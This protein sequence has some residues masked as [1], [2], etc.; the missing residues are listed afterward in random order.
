MAE[1][2]VVL[3][4][5]TDI[6]DSSMAEFDGYR[7]HNPEIAAVVDEFCGGA[8]QHE[9]AP[10]LY[11]VFYALRHMADDGSA[12]PSISAQTAEKAKEELR[13]IEGDI[14]GSSGFTEFRIAVCRLA[15][16]LD[17]LVKDPEKNKR[18]KKLFA[19]ILRMI[20]IERTKRAG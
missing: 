18:G 5:N 12:I 7:R 3:P 19:V 11:A 17:A 20:Q 1:E 16:F 13:K 2:S 4:A 15:L 10:T 6:Y 9:S 14:L 8:G